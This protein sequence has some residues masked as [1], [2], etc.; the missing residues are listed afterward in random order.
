MTEAHLTAPSDWV[1]IRVLGPLR[2][3]SADGQLIRDRDWRTGKNADLLRWLALEAGRPVTV[4]TL[5]DGLWPDVDESRARA[6]LRTAV[7]HLRRVL[8]AESIERTG[9]DVVLKSAWVDAGTFSAMAEHVAARRRE[10]QPAAV[11]AVAREADSLYL[12]DV[13]ASEGTPEAIRQHASSLA[14]AHRRVLADAA[15]LAV[16][17]GWM[18]DAVDYARRLLDEDPVS[19]RASRALMLGYAGMGEVHHALAEFERCREVLAEELGVDPSAQTRAVHLQVLQ[20]GGRTPQRRTAPLVG[21]HAEVDWLRSVLEGTGPDS[22]SVVVTLL[23]RQG[24]GRRRLATATC[25]RAG[26]QL[27]RATSADDVVAAARSGARVVLWAPDVTADQALLTRLLTDPEPVVGSTSVVLAMPAAGED[28]AWDAMPRGEHVRALTMPPLLPEDVERLAEHLLAG[29]VAAAL[30]EEL[31]AVSDGL[32]GLV[33]STANEWAR[34][35]RLVAT[36]SGLALA[37]EGDLA[38]DDPWGRRALARTLPRLEGDAL[39][40]LLVAAMLDEPL[41]PSLLAPLLPDGPGHLRTRATTALEQLVDL[42][43][44]GTSPA[45]VVWKHP[46]LQDAARAWVRPSVR[47]RLHRLIAERAL[48]P[49]AQ[50]IGHWLEAGERELAC[51]AALQ[52]AAESSARGDH[53]GARTHLLQVCSLGDLRD[54]A[55][56]DRIELFEQLGDACAMLRLPDEAANAYGQALE[57][58]MTEAVQDAGRLR[59]KLTSVSDPRALEQVDTGRSADWSAALSGV[60]PTGVAM[61]GGDLETSLREAV[62]QADRNHDR[63]SGFQARVKLAGTVFLPRREFRAVHETL[64][65]AIALGPRPAER[66]HA[67]VVRHLP[68]VLLGNALAAKGPLEAAGRVAA[69]LREER[70]GW[71]LLGMRVLVTH[72]LG[73]PAFDTLWRVLRERVMTGEVDEVVPEL[74]ATGLRVLVEREEYDLAQAFAQHL[75][76]AGGPANHM[77]DHL[78]RIAGAELAAATGDIRYA[79]D[80]MRAVIDDGTA[81]G[82]TLLVPEAA[83]RL[84]ALEAQHNPN[85]ARAA[86]EVYDDIVGAALGGPREEFFRRMARAAVRAAR[87]DHQGA[88]DAMTQA[89]ALAN[90]YG[91]QV[92]AARARRARAEHVRAELPR[93]LTSVPSLARERD[94]DVV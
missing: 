24:S 68:S 6:S 4:E 64:E 23:G 57:I 37:P 7:S 5:I 76:L 49:S 59:R 41:T 94:E 86:F 78:A 9:S 48:I 40:A 70:I 46:K 56:E 3:R 42:A 71:R 30:A 31:T 33:A 87:G 16:E 84:V 13:P 60:A 73:D 12:T 27:T 8:G 28:A 53:H 38:E 22:P 50:R 25:Q 69:E 92:L 45:G 62:A 83:A 61:S 51:V 15:E 77:N 11:L 44:L 82:C 14:A 2:V 52:A 79:I 26:I 88:A 89:S 72:D 20:S 35:G 90:Q 19:E 65:A 39:E 32:P 10:G 21:R 75:P 66:L 58:A 36:D 91:L 43:V 63:R 29:P 34:G 47:R 17:L 18:R 93:T 54:A 1:E 85:A 67:D 81:T 74:A 80:Q 55:A